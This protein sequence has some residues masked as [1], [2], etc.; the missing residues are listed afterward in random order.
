[1]PSSPTP[2]R[3]YALIP[4]AGSGSRAGE[5]GP[6]QYRPLAGQ[7]LVEHTL[8]AFAAVPGLAGVLVAVAPGDTALRS[9]PGRWVVP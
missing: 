9:G 8:A 5:G 7:P 6:K 3:C 4:C 2:P 1:M